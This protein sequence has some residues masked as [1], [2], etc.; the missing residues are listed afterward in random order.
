MGKIKCT[1]DN[2]WIGWIGKITHRI[3]WFR[4]GWILRYMHPIITGT[5]TPIKHVEDPVRF[6]K[7][8]KGSSRFIVQ[9]GCYRTF[10][11]RM[12]FTP[13]S[14]SEKKVD[15]SVTVLITELLIMSLLKIFPFTKYTY[16]PLHRRKSVV[17]SNRR[18]QLEL[19]SGLL[20]NV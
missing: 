12:G 8:G 6:R 15:K 3:Y 13:Q 18:A 11:F 20:T 17:S 14:S 10:N 2:R 19:R 1:S 5:A 9:N 7:W 16:K 4:F